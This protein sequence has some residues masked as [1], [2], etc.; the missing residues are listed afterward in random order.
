[1]EGRI[2]MPFMNEKIKANVH[3]SK[4]T[5]SENSKIRIQI[6]FL[7]NFKNH[8]LSTS[9]CNRVPPRLHKAVC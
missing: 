4:I 9:P 7:S 5:Q 8:A 2:I 3:I 6:Q 1:M